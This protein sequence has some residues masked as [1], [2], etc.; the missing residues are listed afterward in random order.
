MILYRLARDLYADDLSGTGARLYGGRWNNKGKSAVY[1]ASSRALALLEVLV[2][3]QPLI[4]P[5]NYFAVEI[6]V[7]ENKIK[8]VDPQS[9]PEGWNDII[10][11]QILKKI[12]DDFLAENKYLLLKVPSAIVPTE[13][14]YLLNPRHPEME[15]VKVVNKEPFYFDKRLV[16]KVTDQNR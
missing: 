8:Q 5:K 4:I 15:E 11:P 16:S 7:P 14:N 12:G 10:A 3:L 9:L 1:L 13:F 2:H 6:G